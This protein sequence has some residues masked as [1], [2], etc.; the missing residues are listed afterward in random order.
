MVIF[1]KNSGQ[2]NYLITDLNDT[3]LVVGYQLISTPLHSFPLPS[4]VLGMSY[5]GDK[6]QKFSAQHIYNYSFEYTGS[7]RFGDL[8]GTK[9]LV[10]KLILGKLGVK[11]KKEW[12]VGW[13]ARNQRPAWNK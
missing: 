13:K 5:L 1:Y 10:P 9:N 2:L 3:Q 11:V 7:W 6:I 8:V 4:T 12:T